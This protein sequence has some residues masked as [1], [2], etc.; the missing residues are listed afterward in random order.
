MQGIRFSFPTATQNILVIWAK[1]TAPSIEVGRSAPYAPSVT[2]YTL[3]PTDIEAVDYIF[4]WYT[5]PD[6][7]TPQTLLTSWAIAGRELMDTEF[8][9]YDY[10]VGRGMQG[11]YL[12]GG[13]YQWSDPAPGDN[14]IYDRRLTGKSYVAERRGLGFLRSDEIADSGNGFSLLTPGDVF[15]D[16]ETIT[17]LVNTGTVVAPQ[18]TI[19]IH[20]VT[21]EETAGPD[22][23]N[24]HNIA[25]FGGLDIA[26]TTIPPFAS[27]S[28]GKVFEASTHSD[29][30]I[31]QWIFQLSGVDTIAIA[32]HSR[33]RIIL[34]AGEHIK[35]VFKNV[36]G[37]M[38]AY[39]L[40]D[41]TRYR[42]VGEVVC[43]DNK[44]MVG[45]VFADGT[46]YGLSDLPRL[47]DVIMQQPERVVTSSPIATKWN[48]T[49]T[50][51]AGRQYKNG[52]PLIGSG[53]IITYYKNRGKYVVDDISTMTFRVPDERGQ[54]FR[55]LK[56]FDGTTDPERMTQGAGGR[57]AQEI[58]KHR[59]HLHH[60]RGGDIDNNINGGA[61]ITPDV[62]PLDD[63]QVREA[64]G[65]ENRVDNTGKYALIYI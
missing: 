25:A 34:G 39:V 2:P 31:R 51:E 54:S 8:A 33:S 61:W 35:I 15:A 43:A 60:G 45:T 53:T 23:F 42:F 16:Q 19:P 41:D 55:V 4:S 52:I 5:T 21:V 58:L 49:Q 62:N 12:G 18:G 11:P 57:Q 28:D 65:I 10:V 48:E 17:V 46:E 56:D 36:G 37:A 13:V 64:G 7:V 30:A 38:T 1:A 47:Y 44:D 20:P 14:F 32:G 59:H 29:P 3:V 27:I 6:G 26:T 24:T 22:Y 9:V 50:Y 40:E 63:E